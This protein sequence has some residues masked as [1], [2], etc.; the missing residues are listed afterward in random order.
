MRLLGKA[1]YPLCR[2][3]DGSQQSGHE[4]RS[5]PVTETI[6]RPLSRS[7]PTTRTP[8]P[9]AHPDFVCM[10]VDI[11]DHTSDQPNQHEE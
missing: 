9:G 6:Q 10:P 3:V 11:D 8:G 5:G 2:R 1:K 4:A 7:T